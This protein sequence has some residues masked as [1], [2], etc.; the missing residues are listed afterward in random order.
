MSGSGR[1]EVMAWPQHFELGAS[2]TGRL[3]KYRSQ[4]DVSSFEL[5]K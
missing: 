4:S 5:R 1:L 2:S 3:P